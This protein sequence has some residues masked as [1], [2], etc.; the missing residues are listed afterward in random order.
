[1]LDGSKLE[2]QLMASGAAHPKLVKLT[3]S[4]S[5]DS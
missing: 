1:M 5:A 4:P 3:L 2:D